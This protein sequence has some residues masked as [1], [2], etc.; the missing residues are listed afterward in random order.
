MDASFF[1][2]PKNK[3]PFVRQWQAAEYVSV[4]HPE[5]KWLNVRPTDGR[6]VA[7]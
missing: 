4:L 6:E 5:M 7:V 2:D 1:S 3:T